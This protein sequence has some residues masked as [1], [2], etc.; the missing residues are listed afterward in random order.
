MS[1][2]DEIR[3]FV[4]DEFINPA[5]TEE[6]AAIVRVGDVHRRMGFK[7]RVPAIVSAI[8]GRIFC[9]EFGLVITDRQ[10]RPVSTPTTFVYEPSDGTGLL[11]SQHLAS[12]KWFEERTGK[13]VAWTELNDRAPSSRRRPKGFINRARHGTR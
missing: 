5:L 13:T 11:P 3:K 8:G 12:L 7:N 4:F 1:L 2:A 6:R 9:A 10:G